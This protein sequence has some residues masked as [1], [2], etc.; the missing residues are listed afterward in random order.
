MRRPRRFSRLGLFFAGVLGALLVGASVWLDRRGDTVFAPVHAKHERVTLRHDPQGTW[1]RWYE[2]G[3][4]VG[5]GTSPWIATV[6][7]PEHRYD[8]LHLGDSVRVRYLP[9]IPLFARTSD[10]STATV[11]REAAVRTGILSL[12]LWI[13]FGVAGLWI[14]ARIGTPLV[15]AFGLAWMAAGFPLLLRAPTSVTVGGFAGTARVA[16]VSLITKS[17]QNARARRRSRSSRSASLRRLAAPYQ[18]VE[19]HVPLPGGRDSVLAVD[20]VDSGSVGGLVLGAVV[21]VRYDPSAPRRAR[22]AQGSW[23]FVERNRYHY[24]PAV[25]G[26]PL[27]GMLAATGFRARRRR[28]P[29]N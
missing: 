26:A 19:L 18:V 12:L 14:A 13:A 21:P 3:V 9:Q 28:A 22:L 4:G 5:D 1:Y 10:R 20:A 6:E 23:T 15:L 11:A 7:V 29:T 24:L 27:L 8:S 25:I 16:S 17:P 2:V